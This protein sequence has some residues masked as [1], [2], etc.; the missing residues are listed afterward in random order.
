MIVIAFG[1]GVGATKVA[2]PFPDEE[3]AMKWS[4]EF[5]KLYRERFG[6]GRITPVENQ[7]PLESGSPVSPEEF[8][9]KIPD[10][11]SKQEFYL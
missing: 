3:S 6:T 9:A 11:T 7:H 8:L 1:D 10:Q 5:W 2:G 4:E